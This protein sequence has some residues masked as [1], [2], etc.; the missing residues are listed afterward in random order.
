MISHHKNRDNGNGLDRVS[1]Y[2]LTYKCHRYR[3]FNVVPPSRV[4]QTQT[5]ATQGADED[6]ATV[7]PQNRVSGRA[8]STQEQEDSRRQGPQKGKGNCCGKAA[9]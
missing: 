5:L 7:D 6:S 1:E 3:Q 2:T 4:Q 9:E 8:R